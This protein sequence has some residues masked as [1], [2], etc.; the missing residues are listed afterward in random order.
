MPTNTWVGGVLL[1]GSDLFFKEKIKGKKFEN[2]PF[3]F[4]DATYGDIMS[5][6]QAF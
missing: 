4:R 1:S 2:A 5:R 6:E 3:S